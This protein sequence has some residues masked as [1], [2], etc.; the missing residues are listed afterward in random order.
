MKLRASTPTIHAA[1]I[2]QEA[3]MVDGF[4]VLVLVGLVLGAVTL[5]RQTR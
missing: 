3:T 4:T 2:S 1:T 5:E